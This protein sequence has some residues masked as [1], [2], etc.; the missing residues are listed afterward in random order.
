M[1]DRAITTTFAACASF[2]LFAQQPHAAASSKKQVASVPFV[3]CQSNGRVGPLEAPTGKGATISIS[4]EA[5]QRVAY[6]K[7]E[8]STGVLGPRGWYCFGTYG[9]SG[10]TLFVS[11]QPI[12]AAK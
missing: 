7:A 4:P 9:S 2:P 1:I 3:G 6:Y 11:P 12:D 5:G 10:A 8:R